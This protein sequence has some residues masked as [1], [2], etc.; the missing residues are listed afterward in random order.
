MSPGHAATLQLGDRAERR[1]HFSGF[2]EAPRRAGKAGPPREAGP[3]G[4]AGREGA[5][6]GG[7]ARFPCP[8]PGFRPVV[9]PGDW[10]ERAGSVGR[11]RRG[12]PLGKIRVIEW[13]GLEEKSQGAGKGAGTGVGVG[14]RQAW[15]RG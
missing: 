12:D 11:G 10:L 6:P 1:I 13:A 9:N 14:G 8:L 7:S 15:R 3:D 2:W 4:E 5:V